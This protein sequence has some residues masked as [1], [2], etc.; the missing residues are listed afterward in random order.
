M[1]GK[2]WNVTWK[3]I[4]KIACV[5][6]GLAVEKANAVNVSVIT[7]RWVNFLDVYSLRR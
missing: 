1:G 4:K 2:K 5:L 6:M 3:K 7:G